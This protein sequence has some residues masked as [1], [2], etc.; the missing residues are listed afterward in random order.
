MR[1]PILLMWGYTY[2]IIK[3]A[4]VG[5][6]TFHD[7]IYNKIHA[8]MNFRKIRCGKA[9]VGN[10]CPNPLICTCSNIYE[11]EV[12]QFAEVM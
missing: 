4:S 7:Y 6:L 5:F 10:L 1:I 3:S 9:H 2:L 11:K 12:R 8:C